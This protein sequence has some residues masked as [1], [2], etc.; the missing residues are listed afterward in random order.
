MRRKSSGRSLRERGPSPSGID[1]VREG[2]SAPGEGD[3]GAVGGRANGPGHEEAR[4][5]GAAGL[6]HEGGGPISGRTRL[7]D[8]KDLQRYD[9]TSRPSRY[10]RIRVGGVSPDDVAH[11]TGIAI[12]RWGACT[13]QRRVGRRLTDATA[14]GTT[15][16]SAGGCRAVRERRQCG[17]TDGGRSDARTESD[18]RHRT[19]DQCRPAGG[20]LHD[21]S[22]SRRCRP[23]SARPWRSSRTRPRRASSRSTATAPRSPASP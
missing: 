6:A 3:A 8:S 22:R 11:Y 17:R 18:P 9:L 15:G 20:H 2:A 14:R 5:G 12:G 4:P 10:R 1:V 21:R 19:A 13:V 7:P 16:S 23:R